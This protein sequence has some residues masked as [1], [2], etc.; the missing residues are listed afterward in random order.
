MA[1]SFLK[2][3]VDAGVI[4]EDA[5]RNAIYSAVSP[6]GIAKDG[7][8][9]CWSLKEDT[10]VCTG[11]YGAIM[12]CG[13]QV[14][15]HRLSWW[16]N[17]GMPELTRDMVVRHKCDN[18]ACS[19][20][21]HLEIGSHSD[22]V[23]DMYARGR[24]KVGRK[25]RVRASV[26]CTN[27]RAYRLQACKMTDCGRCERCVSLGLDCTFP[28]RHRT[29]YEFKKGECSGENNKHCKLSDAQ[30]S[31][32]RALRAAG[33][34]VKDIAVMFGITPAYACLIIKNKARPSENRLN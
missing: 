21:E 11:G 6:L 33:K 5:I 23:R 7:L 9:R 10:T 26:A 18:P 28:E 4:T 25:P 17:N 1:I 12:L 22:N 16:I 2:S 29:G 30:V 15:L 3:A 19:N 32:M 31:E 27:C 13:T 24:H 8:T 20:P 34:K 14:H